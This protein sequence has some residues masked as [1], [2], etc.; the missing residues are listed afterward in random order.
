MPDRTAEEL[1]AQFGPVEQQPESAFDAEIERLAALHPVA[2]DRARPA[3]AKRLKCRVDTLDRLVR[4][5][6]GDHGGDGQGTE[7]TF[8]EPEP[9]PQPVDGDALL[10]ELAD[11]IREHVMLPSAAAD[12]AAIWVVHTYAHEL[13]RISPILAATSPEKRCGKTTLLSVLAELARRPLPASNISPPALFRTTEKYR[14]TLL[15]DE[16]DTFLRQ[17]DE[18]RGVLNSGHTRE[19]AYVIRTAGDDFEPRRFTTWAPKAIALIGNLPP[20]LADRAIV[21][22]LRRKR[23]GEMVM[24]VRELRA[25]RRLQQQI[26]RWVADNGGALLAASPE[27]PAGLHDRA[28]DNFE[29]LFAIAEVAGADWPER[30]RAAALALA[31]DDQGEDAA[32]V[33]LLSDL[34]DIFEQKG[35]DRITSADLVEELAGMV[36]RP[37]PE[38]RRGKPIS[39][40]QVA[41]LLRRFDVTPKPVRFGHDV[42]KG[43]RLTDLDD[44]F[45]RYLPP[46]SVTRLQTNDGASFSECASVTSESDV[47]D[48]NRPK[49]ASDKGCNRVTD[50]KGVDGGNGHGRTLFAAAT[51]ASEGLGIRPEELV[52]ALAPGDAPEVLAD[53]DLFRAFA[54]SLA[55]RKNGGI[56]A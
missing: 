25:G 34:R 46:S 43:Y 11:L 42:A 3:E 22:K 41:V 4:A 7:V 8:E 37:W 45:S 29:P 15:I 30:A 19:L 26:V 12:A 50:E 5:R 13:A 39:P 9:W 32:A 35:V 21:L 48:R 54:Q 51:T 24:R 16:A 27:S 23:P 40:R 56:P 17:N 44:V 14:P 38:W 33:E 2:Y 55:R 36:E 31:A 53:G 28:A 1:E 20:T 18:L 52:A 47:T 10:R 6:R 49:P